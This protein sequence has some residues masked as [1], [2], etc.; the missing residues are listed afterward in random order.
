M[1]QCRFVRPKKRTTETYD[2]LGDSG[3]GLYMNSALSLQISENPNYFY[4]LKC[5]RTIYI[6]TQENETWV[7][8]KT[9]E[10]WIRSAV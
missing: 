4:F 10:I 3:W 8:A 9:D 7:H 6:D 1:Y 2:V 5:H